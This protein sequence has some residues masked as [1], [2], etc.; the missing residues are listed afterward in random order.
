[1][2][3]P[4]FGGSLAFN[5]DDY[6]PLEVSRLQECREGVQIISSYV[7][8]DGVLKLKGVAFKTGID[9]HTG[10][11]TYQTGKLPLQDAH[12]APLLETYAALRF[13]MGKG[14]RQRYLTGHLD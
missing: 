11:D 2:R 6:A 9:Q 3:G 13:T 7:G 14:L 1:M 8:S 4:V 12:D 5:D 10:I